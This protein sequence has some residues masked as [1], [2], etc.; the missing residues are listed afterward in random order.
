MKAGIFSVFV[1]MALLA[2]S[3]FAEEARPNVI[4]ILYDDM[5]YSDPEYMGGE[6]Q[7]PNL[8]RLADEG[9]TFLNCMNNAKCAPTRISI[10]SGINNL[11]LDVQGE[12]G[13]DF[14][15]NNAACIAE[16]LVDE[17]YAT[18]LAGKWHIRTPPL[19][20]GFQFRF[21]EKFKASYFKDSVN[22]LMHQDQK[23]DKSTL[24]EDYYSTVAYTDYAIKTV[25][26]EAVDKDKP[27]FLYYAV[28]TPHFNFHAPKE[29]IDKYKGRYDEGLDALSKQRF[30]TMVEKGIIDPETWKLSPLA[31]D[32]EQRKPYAWDD[33]NDKEKTYFS[34]KLE[35]IAGMLDIADEQVGRLVDM[36]EETG[37]DENTLIFFLSDNGA[38]PQRGIY[39]GPDPNKMGEDT[40]ETM[41]EFGQ[42]SMGDSGSTVAA[43]Q[44]TPLRGAKRSLWE[45]GMRTSMIVSWPGHMAESARDG[46]VREPVQIMDIAPTIYAAAGVTYPE[47][48]GQRTIDPMDGTSLL[49]LLNGESIEERAFWFSF[50]NY[51]MARQGNWKVLGNVGRRNTWWLFDLEKDPSESTDLSECM[52]ELTEKLREKAMSMH[53][54]YKKPNSKK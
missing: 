40:L 32:G 7:M 1:S 6:A 30:E 52:P 8:T 43:F 13:G 49:P 10:M 19:E 3:A 53:N 41:G 29:Y 34:R 35:V 39:G 37:Q 45:G 50:L 51:R 24:P 48:L 46:Y 14:I 15:E 33:F 22:Q 54:K 4:I 16:L 17:G 12:A 31:H 21:G 5:G 2:A 36:L 27:F 47:T 20:S 23:I 44:N 18:I 11:K 28:H 25:K 42:R 26:E 9:V 38:C